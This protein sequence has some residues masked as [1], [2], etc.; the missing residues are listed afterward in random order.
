MFKSLFLV[1]FSFIFTVAADI[2]SEEKGLQ[3]ARQMEEAGKGFLSDSSE[4]EMI[5]IDSYGTKVNRKLTVN[6]RRELILME[7]VY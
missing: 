4:M 6:R 2:T 3:V 7:K 5:L 1:F